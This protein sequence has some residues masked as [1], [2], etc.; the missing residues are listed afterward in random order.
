MTSFETWLATLPA[1]GYDRHWVQ[2]NL[3]ALKARFDNDPS[4]MKPCPPPPTRNVNRYDE[5]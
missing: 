3:P 1:L 2:R 4:P 5:L